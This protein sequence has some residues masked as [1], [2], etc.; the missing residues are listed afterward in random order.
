MFKVIALAFY[1]PLLFVVVLFMV[2]AVTT[3][4]WLGLLAAVLAVAGVWGLGIYK[5]LKEAKRVE[6]LRVAAERAW[7]EYAAKQAIADRVAEEEY[8][9]WQE[10]H[11]ARER[12][13]SRAAMRGFINPN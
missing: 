2:A 11:L 7:Q 10:A 3:V 13:E 1:S 9:A 5:A 8:A 12:M 4:P 6:A